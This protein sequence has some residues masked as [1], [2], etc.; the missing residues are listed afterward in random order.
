M[1]FAEKLLAPG[2]QAKHPGI[3]NLAAPPKIFY[4]IDL[5]QGLI[6]PFV[7]LWKQVRISS[8]QTQRFIL[9]EEG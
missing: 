8:L 6:S 7:L 5:S 3:V 2:P 1:L 4:F 9:L